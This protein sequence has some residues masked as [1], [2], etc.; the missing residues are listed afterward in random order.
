VIMWENGVVENAPPTALACYSSVRLAD[1]DP[2]SSFQGG[3]SMRTFIP[4]NIGYWMCGGQCR[5]WQSTSVR[6]IFG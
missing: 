6:V 4:D 2:D 1:H 3:H 5:S